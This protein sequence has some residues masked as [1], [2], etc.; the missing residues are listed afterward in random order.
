MK[1]YIHA[2]YDLTHL[3]KVGQKVRCKSDDKMFPGTVKEVYEDH[4]IVDV[5]E[6]SDHMWYEKGWNI[7][8]VY[9]DYNF[10]AKTDVK[11]SSDEDDDVDEFEEY[12]W[13]YSV[14]ECTEDGDEIDWLRNF[15][16]LQD[17]VDYAEDYSAEND[18]FAHVV[19][20]P[21][22]DPDDGEEVEEYYR[23]FAPYEPYESVWD[24][25]S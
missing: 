4:I 20:M 1:R 12:T 15:E 17:A 3:F 18:T 7:S 19:F 5:P 23:E 13:H 22:T 16:V 11:A 6:I 9:P 21:D 24:N 2:N 25:Y 14:Y 8:N 10:T